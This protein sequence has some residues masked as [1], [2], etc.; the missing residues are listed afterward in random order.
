MKKP[1]KY[2]MLSC[3]SAVC[4]S[5]NARQADSLK[6][7]LSADRE[8]LDAQYDYS[9]RT[10]PAMLSWWDNASYSSVGAEFHFENGRLHHPQ[11]YDRLVMGSVGT[12]SIQRQKKWTFHGRFV[13]E[14]GSIDSVR[15]NL[16][17]ALRKNG[18]PSFYFCRKTASRWDIQKYGLEATASRQIGDRWSV[19]A[20]AEYV[21]DLAFRKSDTRNSQ[22][23]LDMHIAL[24]GTYKVSEHHVVSVGADFR[25]V[26]EKPSFSKVYESGPDYNILLMNGLGTYIRELE[27]NVSWRGITPGA[28][29]QWMQTGERNRFSLTYSFSAGNDRWMNNAIQNEDAQMNWTDYAFMKHDLLFSEIIYFGHSLL[30]VRGRGEL[31]SGH[32]STWNRTTKAYIQNYDYSSAGFGLDAEWRPERGVLKKAGAGCAWS[33]ASRRDKSYDYFFSDSSLEVSASVQA[34]VNAGRTFLS[35]TADGRYRHS[36]GVTHNPGAAVVSNNEYTK[37]VGEPLSHWKEVS[38]A[39][40]GI[41]LDID[42][43][44]KKTLLGTGVSA[45]YSVPAGNVPQAYVK[46]DFLNIVFFLNVF[47]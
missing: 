11:T 28:F 16:S 21:G 43:P 29:A 46:T 31:L 32:G 8:F 45:L 20:T 47:F 40:A 1:G 44:V 15:A 42:I 38:Y 33:S 5:L 7:P 36:I 26:K 22:T 17:C 37:Y 23:T 4:M 12:R 35:V 13:Y 19:G 2:I 24:S 3:L 30:N 6:I 25:R 34:G 9:Y 39:D 18:S 10:S 41:A 27:S 14:N